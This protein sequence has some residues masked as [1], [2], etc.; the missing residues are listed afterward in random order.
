MT[1]LRRTFSVIY[2]HTYS[3]KTLSKCTQ[4]QLQSNIFF[5]GHTRVC[6][7]NVLDLQR[8]RN[9]HPCFGSYVRNILSVIISKTVCLHYNTLLCFSGCIGGFVQVQKLSHSFQKPYDLDQL[10][11]NVTIVG[12]YIY[13]IFSMIAAGM[14]LHTMKSKPIIVFVQSLLLFIQVSFQGKTFVI[15]HN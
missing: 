6:R 4:T 1:Q 13:A 14:Y 5:T 15:C 9:D 10:L 7:R 12:A 2:A 8:N 3:C 11:A